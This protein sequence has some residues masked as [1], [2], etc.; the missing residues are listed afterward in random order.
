MTAGFAILAVN[1][2]FTCAFVPIGDFAPSV[3]L[4]WFLNMLQ[5]SKRVLLEASNFK[6]IGREA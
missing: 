2:R 5:D 3:A 6:V 4:K 1:C